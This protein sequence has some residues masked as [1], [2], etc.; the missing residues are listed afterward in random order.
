MGTKGYPGNVDMELD[1]RDDKV[2][3]ICDETVTATAVEYLTNMYRTTQR[4]YTFIY[5][6]YVD[7]LGHDHF[8]CSEQYNNGVAV[9]D[10]QV[11]VH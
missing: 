2:Y 7:V 5:F 9:V 1:C 3:R 10:E 8:W 11:S 6:A 4:S